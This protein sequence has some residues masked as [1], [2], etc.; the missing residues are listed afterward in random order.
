MSDQ[1]E[2]TIRPSWRQRRVGTK[3]IWDQAL[4]LAR[5]PEV[6]T[7][8]TKIVSSPTRQ[9]VKMLEI[10]LLLVALGIVGGIVLWLKSPAIKGSSAA[11]SISIQEL[12]M[13]AHLESLPI[14]ELEDQSLIYPTLAQQTK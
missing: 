12:H 10:S 13:L 11:Q 3:L 1:G 2:A 4:R 8:Q 9:T 14:Q 7:I 5:N 6:Q